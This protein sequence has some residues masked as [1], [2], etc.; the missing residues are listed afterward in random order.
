MATYKLS[1]TNTKFGANTTFSPDTIT[2]ATAIG[3]GATATKSN[4]VVIGNGEVSEILFGATNATVSFGSSAPANR[5]FY[6]T[7]TASGSTTG[8][9][10]HFGTTIQ[11]DVTSS[12]RVFYSVPS[13][14]AASFTLGELSHFSVEGGTV[15]AGSTVSFQNGFVVF[16]TMTGATTN[17]AFKGELTQASGR[18]NLYMSGSA[19]NYISGP[20]GIG[21]TS[22]TAVNLSVARTITG[23]TSAYNQYNDNT[24]QSDV[25]TNAYG[26]YEKLRTAAT[27]FTCSNA[28]AFYA[29]QITIGAGSTV[30]NGFGFRVPSSFNTATNNYAFH[31]NI[32]ANGTSNWNVYA[33]GSAPNYFGGNVGISST[34]G[35]ASRKLQIGGFI[36]G[37]LGSNGIFI[38]SQVQSDVTASAIYY[39]TSS[40]TQA[41]SFNITNLVHYR[42]NQG[43]IG[44]GSSITT[45][46][47]FSVEASL[48]G[49]STNYG[50]RGQIPAGS[51]RYNLYMDGTADNL[52]NGDLY[53]NGLGKGLRI[54]EGTDAKMGVATLVA[55][56]VTVA[57]TSVTANSRIFLTSQSDGGTPGWVRVS[58]RVA[59]TSFTITSSSG[60]DTSVIAYQ[61]IEPA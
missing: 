18:W 4:Q 54:K 3:Q 60:A 25:T 40:N 15:G 32:N 48:I 10:Y 50:F 1:T 9:G 44:A 21:T 27:T 61:I 14:Q 16:N 49:A 26:V 34:N 8:R 39:S 30:T 37:G 28:N 24:I 43:T 52:L 55:G 11:S 20:L 29:D 45:Q 17:Y 7:G 57:N 53:L 38:E 31:G 59:G 58:A 46:T 5:R 19:W 12:Y 33:Q 2:N 47:G 42:A 51:N 35:I 36:T 22:L 6:I 13:T 23:A 56:T 41:A